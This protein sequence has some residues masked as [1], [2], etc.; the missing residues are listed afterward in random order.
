MA[1]ACVAGMAALS[2][3]SVLGLSTPAFAALTTT[4]PG[5]TIVAPT[6]P[7]IAPTTTNSPAGNLQI[8]LA[9]GTQWAVLG[10]TIQLTVTDSGGN[11]ATI[12][13]AG[14]PVVAVTDPGTGNQALCAGTGCTVSIAA[15]VLTVTLTGL[16]PQVV[17]TTTAEQLTISAI[18]Y[19][20][21]GAAAGAVQVTSP[22][23]TTTPVA[24]AANAVVA[25][26][27]AINVIAGSTPVIAPGATTAAGPQVAYLNG[28][29]TTWAIG[30]KIYMAVARNDATNCETVGRPDSVGFAGTPLVFASTITNG[31]T[32]TPTLTAAY[33]TASGT[34]ANQS[35][36]AT[37]SGVNNEMVLTFTNAG[38]I[39]STAQN[40]VTIT[41][42]GVSYTVSADVGDI[43]AAATIPPANTNNLGNVDIATS[44]NVLPTFT[45]S[46][47]GVP[48]DSL[49]GGSTIGYPP[50]LATALNNNFAIGTTTITTVGFP[51][52]IPAGTTLYLGA[53]G[54][55]GTETVVTT[56]IAP[57]GGGGTPISITPT[58]LFHGNGTPVISF[59]PSN[60]NINI[61][62]VVVTANT[63]STTLQ[64]NITST[65]G[66]VVNQAVSPITIAEGTPGA[67]G[68]GV[69][70]WAC[71]ALSPGS[72]VGAAAE[73]NALP[74]VAAT[75]GGLVV[76]NSTLLTPGSQTGP[77]ELAFQVTT[78]S[79][80]TAGTV[81]ISG[82]TVNFP[83]NLSTMQAN[84]WYGA[85][86]AAAACQDAN[87]GAHIGGGTGYGKNPFTVANLAGRIFGQ[88]QDDTAA[89]VFQQFPPVT[90]FTAPACS[91]TPT[92]TNEIPAVLATNAS[93]QDALSASY[94]AGQLSTGILTTNVNT[95]SAA[96]LNALR[97]DGVTEVFVV[98]GPYVVSP[99]DITQLQNTPSYNCGG[100]SQR[101]TLNGQPIDLV[102][103]QIYGQT[104]DATAAAVATFVG[105]HA[106]GT[107]AFPGAYGG[108]YND[109]T[110]SN[111]SAASSAPDTA[112]TTAVL[113]TDQS[114]QDA[115]SASAL[116]YSGDAQNGNGYGFPLLL[117]GQ[118]SL[119]PE[120]ASALTNLAVQ[121][122]IVMGGPIAISDTV[123][124][125]IQAMGISV[126]RIAGQDFTDTSQL[127]GRFDLNSVVPI[128]A[129]AGQANGLD[130]D[131]ARLTVAR[132]DYYTDAIVASRASFQT[133]ILLTWDP[134]NEGNPAGTNYLGTF[135]TAAGQGM[136]IDLGSRPLDG[137]INNLLFVG[138]PFAIS[139][140]LAAAIGHSLNG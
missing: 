66:E 88:V 43:A 14:A 26:P 78:A 64:Y 60:A 40:P 139:N 6:A 37:F 104:A 79:T 56:A 41:I 108:S 20:T 10:N 73:F 122:V 110:G 126:L 2:V 12:S 70:G 28:Q 99:A 107:G 25:Q 33:T 125:Q 81:T 1:T 94:L 18:G 50:A 93:Y 36:C 128:G 17:A 47:H 87:N 134:N 29:N 111:G 32:T 44:Y 76:G 54:G 91:G 116:G 133:P 137:T 19:T 31:A 135:L 97:I 100:T 86:S 74:T 4:G 71:I 8:N 59:G 103:Q 13:F 62:N 117:T 109:T 15:N 48:N 65:G 34:G 11:G 77:T 106:P 140:A 124:T 61:N 113:A 121:Q 58:V 72:A 39:T 38:S 35:S 101:T 16:V 45:Q 118:A 52:A 30:D 136:G 49:V 23:F 132:G 68:S 130:Y 63:P 9:A 69:V 120:A 46:L 22:G 42:A 127:L 84:L 96:A 85:S 102:V 95:L 80:G 131:P 123:L 3:I 114:F 115:A 89:Q 90:P 7:N 27:P 119:S 138:G 129:S 53:P 51:A 21:V 55:M 67:L 98:G 83:T 75:G 5:S 92:A 57:P 112:V 105:P 24:G 82:I